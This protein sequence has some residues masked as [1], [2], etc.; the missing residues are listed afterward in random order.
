MTSSAP[1]GPRSLATSGVAL[2]AT[3]EESDRRQ[4]SRN[5]THSFHIVVGATPYARRALI[6]TP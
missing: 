1:V 5:S 3:N 2:D 6:G 4:R